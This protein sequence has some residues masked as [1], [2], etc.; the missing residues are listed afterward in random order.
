MHLQKALHSGYTKTG[1]DYQPELAL[2]QGQGVCL[3]LLSALGPHL[4]QPHEGPEHVDSV[5][6]NSCASVV[7]VQRPWFLCVLQSLWPHIQLQRPKKMN[8]VASLEVLCLI[9]LCQG[10]LFCFNLIGTF[11]YILWLL[12]LCFQGNSYMFYMCFSCL[13]FFFDSFSST[14]L[15]YPTSLVLFYLVLFY[16][17]SLEAYLFSKE[18]QKGSGSRFHGS[19]E[20]LGRVEKGET[21]IRIY[22]IM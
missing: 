12:V 1:C 6:V 16:Y 9:I 7:C 8:S 10:V 15:S 3:L 20:G 17:Y 5:S 22:C 13:F 11:G 19:R 18:R 14:H 4:V 21:T 2:S